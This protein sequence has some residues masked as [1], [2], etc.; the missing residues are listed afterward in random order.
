[1]SMK[2]RAQQIRRRE[3]HGCRLA[4]NTTIVTA[5]RNR[6]SNLSEALATWIHTRPKKIIICDWGSEQPLSHERLGVPFGFADLVEIHRLEADRWILT[7]A[8]NEALSR[9]TTKFTLKLDCDHAITSDFF[10]RNLISY[11][12]FARGHWRSQ[13]SSQHYVNGAFL[14]CSDLLRESGYYDERITTYGWDDS[15]LYERLYDLSDYATTLAARTVYHLPQ[16]EHERTA[17]Q[18]VSKEALLANFLGMKKTE[19][20]IARNRLL[21]RMQWPW[22][23]DMFDRR[24][25]IRSSFVGSKP[26]EQ[27]L[28]EYATIRTFEMFYGWLGQ[29]KYQPAIEAYQAIFEEDSSGS[30]GKSSAYLIPSIVTRYSTALDTNDILQQNI[31]RLCLIAGSSVHAQVDARL[32]TLALAQNADEAL[33]NVEEYHPD[34]ESVRPPQ[35]SGVIN[36]RQRVYVD[37]QHGLGNRLRAIASASVVAKLTDKELVIVWQPDFHCDARLS[38]LFKYD[39]PVE[40][41]SF[42][43]EAEYL[44]DHVY[45]YMTA[46]EGSDKDELLDL[47]ANGSIYVRSAFSVNYGSPDWNAEDRFLRSLIPHDIVTGLTMAIPNPSDLSVHIRMAG[48]AAVEDLPYERPDNWTQH[49]HEEIARWR[50]RCHFSKFFSRVDELIGAK[51]YRSIFVAAD[52]PEVYQEFRSR[53]G[54]RVSWLHRKINDR[55]AEQLQ[56]ALADLILLSRAK[57]ILGSNWSSFSEIAGRLAHDGVTRE[58]CGVDF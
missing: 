43:A 41:E 44:C 46:E 29:D 24:I 3:E 26:K 33:Q 39:G 34:R 52:L 9:V 28:I 23:Q 38:D 50:Q 55:S 2:L 32:E 48:G 5:C 57:H 27:G 56:Y 47:S 18:D 21:T 36:K 10:Q 4:A 54:D 45:N 1:M 58:L 20:L 25:E 49:D 13:R 22:T 42:V 7:W 14:S 6:E 16:E 19:F 8:F 30:K 12:S 51:N 37:A 17:A 31:L 53:Y 15:D 40:E 11:N 35:V